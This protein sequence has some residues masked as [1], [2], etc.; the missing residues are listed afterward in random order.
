MRFL[1]IGPNVFDIQN[2]VESDTSISSLNQPHHSLSDSF[3]KEN[4]P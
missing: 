4:D 3:G 2:A 1:S